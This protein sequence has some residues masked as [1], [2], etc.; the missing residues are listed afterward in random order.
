MTISD[1]VLAALAAGVLALVGAYV[2]H[3]LARGAQREMYPSQMIAALQ[4]EVAAASERLDASEARLDASLRRE[5]IRDNYIHELRGDL[6][7]AGLPVRPWP[8][9]L[10]T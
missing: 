6:L 2:T 8:D 3:R 1:A 7:E 5:R 10:T 4:T 9:G